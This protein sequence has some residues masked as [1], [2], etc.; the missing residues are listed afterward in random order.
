M[1]LLQKSVNNAATFGYNDGLAGQ[2]IADAILAPLLDA[3]YAKAPL[4]NVAQTDIKQESRVLDA[5]ILTLSGTNK[6]GSPYLLLNRSFSLEES[7]SLHRF[8]R[9]NYR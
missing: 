4:S 7:E 2:T 6:E 9:A 1:P 5:V 8:F 3:G